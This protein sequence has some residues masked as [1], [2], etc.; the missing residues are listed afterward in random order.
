VDPRTRRVKAVGPEAPRYASQDVAVRN[1]FTYSGGQTISDLHLAEIAFRHAFGIFIQ[2]V[3]NGQLPFLRWMKPDLLIHPLHA[4]SGQATKL[5]ML[6]LIRMGIACGARKAG[7]YLGPELS[8]LELRT[9][10][11]VIEY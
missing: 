1:G 8:D 2:R 10:W 3:R 5:E 4:G 6:T 9:G 7:V 11:Y